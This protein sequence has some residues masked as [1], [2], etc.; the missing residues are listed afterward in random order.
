VNS[1]QQ[2]LTAVPDTIFYVQKNTTDK[3]AVNSLC[4]YN[5]F[6]PI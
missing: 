4:F 5:I 6:W 3:N 2:V 1:I